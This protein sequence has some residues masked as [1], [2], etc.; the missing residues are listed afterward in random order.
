M[1]RRPADDGSLRM[2]SILT[3]SLARI[4][5]PWALKNLPPFRPVAL[6]LARLTA[7]DDTPIAQV[8]QVLRTD[9]A[10][11]AE[12]LRLANSALIGSRARINSV[13]H[14]V[15]FLGLER[16]KA[17]S[18]TIALRD[19]VST[20][21]KADSLMQHCWKYNLATAIVCEWMAGFLPLEPEACYTA[22]LMHDIG[23]LALLRGFPEEYERAVAT[24][25]DHNFDLLQAEKAAFDIDH[26]EAGRWLMEQWDFSADLK[27]VVA[28]H[29]LTPDS[30]TPPLVTVVYI[31]WQ[32]ADMLGY[33]PLA[34]RSAAT[35]EEITITLP[36]A[37]RQRIFS[38]LDELPQSVS[39]KIDAAESVHA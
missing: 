28:F 7:S 3:P 27:D 18:M 8:Q 22:G 35:I 32:I 21:T 38:G 13:A 6:K 1:L 15:E 2:S 23:R 31:G 34:T 24:I 10:F 36:D 39:Q 12:V 19:F 26:C 25:P 5:Q 4:P 29:H 9:L 20:S 17:L 11:S 30:K 14:A 16:L 37:A 33:S